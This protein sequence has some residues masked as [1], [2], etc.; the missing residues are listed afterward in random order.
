MH[1]V[2]F[3]VGEVAVPS[4]AVMALLGYVAALLSILKLTKSPAGRASGLAP[5]RAWDLFIVMFVASIIGAKLGHVFFEA[6]GHIGRNGQAIHNVAELL[7]DDPW[8]WARITSAGYVWYGGM[9][10]ALAT[11]AVYFRRRPELKAWAYCDAFSP[12]IMIGAAFG[13]VGCFMAGC[14]HG[15]PTDVPWALQFV[16]THELVHPTQAYDAFFAF[17]L[18]AFL[19][20]RFPRRRFDGELIAWLLILYP[21]LRSF[22]EV[23]RGDA[24]RGHVGVLST[25]QLISIPLFLIGL[26]LMIR[27]RRLSPPG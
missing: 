26:G 3:T 11:A 4:Y 6:D 14:C 1:P 27:G 7:A 21:L 9:L 12:A 24:E 16:T 10:G 13:R 25:S 20:F 19:F 15:A 22:T 5:S 18:W 23:F 2:L 17:C 8:H